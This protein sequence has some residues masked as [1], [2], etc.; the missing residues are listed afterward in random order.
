MWITR[1]GIQ[2]RKMRIAR[3]LDR[4]RREGTQVGYQFT[5]CVFD[6]IGVDGEY[7][8]KESSDELD[9]EV[10]CFEVRAVADDLFFSNPESN[11]GLVEL[12]DRAIAEEQFEGTSKAKSRTKSTYGN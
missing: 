10:M 7:I 1:D 12:I 4:G 6:L 2:S 5:R 9:E 11:D 3:A 8:G